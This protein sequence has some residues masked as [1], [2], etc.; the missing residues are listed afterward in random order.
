MNLLFIVNISGGLFQLGA[1]MR[2][3]TNACLFGAKN[4]A[5]GVNNIYIPPN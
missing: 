5:R 1:C 4:N 3:E 2:R